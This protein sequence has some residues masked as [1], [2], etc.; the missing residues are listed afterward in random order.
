MKTR[1]PFLHDPNKSRPR[2]TSSYKNNKQLHF[3]NELCLS[4]IV[5]T[6]KLTLR[7]SRIQYTT[8]RLLY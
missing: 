3:K 7:G 1:V 6:V 4:D 5:S 8:T 2:P